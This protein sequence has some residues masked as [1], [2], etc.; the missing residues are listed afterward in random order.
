[1]AT[2]PYALQGTD[3]LTTAVAM[4]AITPSDSTAQ[5]K[6]IRR[7]FVGGA[8][9][10]ALIDIRENTVTHLNCNAGSYL[11][12]FNVYMVLATGTTATGLVGYA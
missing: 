10:V 2:N 5:P 3:P 7:I 11:G 1:M 4:F 8:G 6:M 12:D 9:N